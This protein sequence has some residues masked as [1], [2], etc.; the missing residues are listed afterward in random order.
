M[1]QNLPCTTYAQELDA[2]RAR[3]T[4][5]QRRRDELR[6]RP[7]ETYRRTE[8]EQQLNAARANA[9]RTDTFWGKAHRPPPGGAGRR[10]LRLTLET[11]R[12]REQEQ[13]AALERQIQAERQ[14]LE[15]LRARRDPAP[16]R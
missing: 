8:V 10:P 13:T 14:A 12:Q 5:E 11:I 15:A 9:E 16:E 7:D 3:E 6:N 1:P 2:R 4:A